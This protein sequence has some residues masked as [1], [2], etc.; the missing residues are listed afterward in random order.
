[1]PGSSAA[2]ETV[3]DLR[4]TWVNYS[5]KLTEAFNKFLSRESL[6]N[7]TLSANRRTIKAHQVR[8]DNQNENKIN[9]KYIY[10]S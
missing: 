3:Q 7:V 6:C 10:C 2:M 5:Q 8:K 4:L 1:M 9:N